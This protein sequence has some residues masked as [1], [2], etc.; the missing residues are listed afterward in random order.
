MV[1]RHLQNMATCAHPATSVIK[2]LSWAGWIANSFD[3]CGVTSTSDH[4]NGISVTEYLEG[5]APSEDETSRES[6]DDS[7][8]RLIIKNK[9]F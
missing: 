6:E 2:W 7:T 3:D 8:V 5:R 4:L 1:Q 9:S